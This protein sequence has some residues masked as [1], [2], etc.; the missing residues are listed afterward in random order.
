MISYVKD[1]SKEALRRQKEK[2]LI[3]KTNETIKGGTLVENK[4]TILH[5][6]DV[7]P[8]SF[9]KEK[10]NFDCKKRL[11]KIKNIICLGYEKTFVMGETV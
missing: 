1:I 7:E 11:N 4:E 2:L 6:S 3:R 8:F 10:G 5:E 9:C